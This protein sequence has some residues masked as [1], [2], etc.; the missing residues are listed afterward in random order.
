[1]LTPFSRLEQVWRETLIHKA[2]VGGTLD[3]LATHF[4]FTRPSAFGGDAWRKALR[5]TAY[6]PRGTLG[7]LHDVLEGAYCASEVNF[8]A[9]VTASSPQ[10]LT[11]VSGDEASFTDCHVGRVARVTWLP[12]ERVAQ[13]AMTPREE[14]ERTAIFRVVGPY[15]THPSTSTTLELAS[16]STSYWAGAHFGAL[17]QRVDPA[18]A[19]VRVELLAFVFEEPG[20]GFIEDEEG[21]LSPTA[22][23]ES[24]KVNLLAALDEDLSAPT[25]LLD[26]PGVDRSVVD[27]SLTGGGILMDPRNTDGI[28]PAPPKEGVDVDMPFYLAGEQPS[29][30]EV[31]LD[32]QLVAGVRLEESIFSFCAAP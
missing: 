2:P 9:S 17:E 13:L 25:Y 6:G 20:R 31:V 26:P 28:A 8:V 19:Q 16:V 24:C 14:L 5:A 4:G 18:F 23:G 32:A 30:I 22:F 21:A 10:T 29:R 7:Y 27:P 3:R 11:Y 1:M 12:E 15:L